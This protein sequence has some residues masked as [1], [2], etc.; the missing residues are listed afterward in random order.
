MSLKKWLAV[1]GA[2]AFILS[3]SIG[4]LSGVTFFVVLFRAVVSG[5]GFSGL[6]YLISLVVK[7]YLPELLTVTKGGKEASKVNPEGENIDILLDDEGYPVDASSGEENRESAGEEAEEGEASEAEFEEEFIEEVPEAES[8][9]TAVPPD[10]D[11]GEYT[12]IHDVEEDIDEL[13]DLDV[14]EGSFGSS[15][16]GADGGEEAENFPGPQRSKGGAD[17]IDILGGE[18]DTGS[19]AKA[20]RTILKKDREG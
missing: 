16:N 2:I 14:F 15:L 17:A 20:V 7:K 18:H 10:T 19:M 3:F 11:S 8:S 12:D 13:P 4:L 9:D 6:V 5:A 1:T